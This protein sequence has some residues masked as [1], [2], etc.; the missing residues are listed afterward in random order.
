MKITAEYI[1]KHIFSFFF[2]GGSWGRKRKENE[3]IK[4]LT[5]TFDNGNASKYRYEDKFCV[6]YNIFVLLFFIS[7]LIII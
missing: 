6:N 5:M 1:S 7:I 3:H 2:V 4:S